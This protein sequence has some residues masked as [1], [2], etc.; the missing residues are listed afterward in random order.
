MLERGAL[1]LHAVQCAVLDEAD[2]MLRMGFKEDCE[3]IFERMP[4]AGARQTMLWSATVPPWV[5]TLAATYC[6]A[7][8]F[9][10][11]VG[12]DARK[13]PATAAFG[14][15]VV[16]SASRPD[17]LA[18]ALHHA[19]AGGGSTGAGRVL[20][21]TD[22]K[23]EANELA[24]LRVNRVRLAALTGDMS[25]AAREGALSDFKSGRCD[26]LCATDVA[27]RGLDIPEVDTV[28]HY[29]L[30]AT[31][32]A[33]V[34]RSGRTARAGRSGAVVALMEPA[35]WEL[36]GR[37]ERAFGVSFAVRPPPAVDTRDLLRE[38]GGR[39]T[40]RL[41]SV[42]PAVRAA[43]ADT[44][45][46]A[47]ALA[48]AGGVATAAL[49]AALA[50]AALGAD[51]GGAAAVHTSLLTGDRATVTV[52][53]QPRS[54]QYT[55]LTRTPSPYAAAGTAAADALAAKT[56]LAAVLDA[57]SVPATSRPRRLLIA[58]DTGHAFVFDLPVAAL[59]AMEAAITAAVGAGTP[60]AGAHGATAAPLVTQLVELPASVKDNIIRTAAPTPDH[61]VRRRRGS[62]SM[63]RDGDGGSGG[64]G[65]R[66]GDRYRSRDRDGGRERAS[67]G[68]GGDGYRARDRYRG[69]REGG[70]GGAS[71][72]RDR[73]GGDG[74]GARS[75][76]RQP[77]QAE[78][79]GDSSWPRARAP[80]AAA[81]ASEGSSGSSESRWRDDR[82]R[83]ASPPREDREW[84]PRRRAASAF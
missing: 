7:P 12:D 52:A 49:E 9:I 38:A 25:Q 79:G 77:Q 11:L 44:G 28:I 68:D 60:P 17:V 13:L 57:A 41:A 2:E 66:G 67:G 53:L 10:D 51:A 43:V 32:E 45:M 16:T 59:A 3:K 22:T 37:W 46:V 56:A 1:D 8:Q 54:W 74:G 47:A 14:A 58:P 30:P 31:Q 63:R 24:R 34:H 20:V 62:R 55:S 23:R 35:E 76:D 4:A 84:A 73:D 69:A 70:E 72:Y 27:A 50:V 19:V 81:W 33:F 5:R 80:R 18:A 64:G 29:R 78:G 40:A 21:F 71:R 82:P 26:V 15:H 42:T 36:L 61:E 48:A 39:V 83:R 65:F 75:F 6:A